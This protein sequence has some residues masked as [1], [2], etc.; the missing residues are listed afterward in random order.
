MGRFTVCIDYQQANCRGLP[1]EFFMEREY[2]RQASRVCNNCPVQ[3]DCYYEALRDNLVGTWGGV[4]HGYPGKSRSHSTAKD[5]TELFRLFQATY[6]TRL[7]VTRDTFLKLYGDG[8]S[9][10]KRALRAR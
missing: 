10:L 2:H 3:A 5:A 9:G 6:I 1:T 8:V 7:G 4:W